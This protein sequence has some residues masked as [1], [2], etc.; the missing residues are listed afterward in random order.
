MNPIWL[1]RMAR[2]VR[3]PPSWARVKLVVGV[4]LACLGLFAV[5]YFWGWPESLTPQK[6][7]P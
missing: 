2:W 5:E 7:R 4:V 1:L 3:N 6:I